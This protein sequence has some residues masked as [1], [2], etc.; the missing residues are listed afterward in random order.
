MSKFEDVNSVSSAFESKGGGGEVHACFVDEAMRSYKTH[1]M[2]ALASQ[3]GSPVDKDV[4]NAYR[5]GES[6][7]ALH[8]MS[9]EDGSRVDVSRIDPGI[10]KLNTDTIAS[11]LAGYLEKKWDDAKDF[12]SLEAAA[13]LQK[14]ADSAARN[15]GSEIL[16]KIYEDLK[17][18]TAK[19]LRQAITK[20]QV[21]DFT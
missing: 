14:F 17:P 12:G 16:G 20:N 13:E 15:R 9:I 7:P 4:A 3:V 11:T 5:H 10:H 6:H 19:H 21:I 2:G 18:D 1:G 8:K